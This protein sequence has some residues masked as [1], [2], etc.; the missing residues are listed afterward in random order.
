MYNQSLL[1]GFPII[2]QARVM[3]F[4]ELKWKA[5]AE[6]TVLSLKHRKRSAQLAAKPPQLPT[7]NRWCRW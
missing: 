5:L 1:P 3:H 6:S 4:Y 2:L 7:F